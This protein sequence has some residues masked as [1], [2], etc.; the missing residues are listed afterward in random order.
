M[1]RPEV[2]VP[3]SVLGIL[4]AMITPLPAFLLDI[5]I[6]ANITLSTIV[7]LVSM[8]IRRPADFSVFPTTLL[9]MTLFRLALNV[10]SSRLILLNGSKGTSAAGEVIES[11]GNFVVGGNF[12][13]G[14]VIFLVL[15]AI[16]Y[17]VINHGAVRISEVT[18]RF[19]LD[20]LPGK[21]MSIDADL[22]GGLINEAEAKARRKSLSAEAEFYGAMDGATRFTQRDAVA[23]ILITGINIIAGFLI[24]VLQHNMRMAQALETYTVLTIGDGL[25]TVIPALMISISGG[26]IVT[27][28]SSEQEMGVDFEKQIFG[29]HQPLLLASGVLGAMALFPG[30]PKIPFLLLAGGVGYTGYRIRQKQRMAVTAPPAP[31]P[32][33]AKDSLESLMK[34]EPLSVEVG[35]GLVKLVEGAE[36]SPLLRRIAGL[37]RQLASELGYILPPVRV[38]DNLSLKVREYVVLLKGA[39]IARCELP[40]GCDLAIP[41][42]TGSVPV[43]GMPTKDPAFG[44][45]ALWISAELAERARA[46]GCTVVDPLSVMTTHLSE[47][48]RRH[49]HEIFS[50]QD[51]KR[52]LDRVSEENPRVVDDLVPKLLPLPTV[53]RVFQNLLR[54]RVSIRDANTVLES[55]GEAAGVTRNPLLLTE[56]VRQS[57]R[58]SL[59]KPHLNTAG[60]LPVFF[61]DPELERAIEQAVE[62][63]ESTSH[64][65]LPPQKVGELLEAARSAVNSGKSGWALLASAGSRSFVRQMLEANHPQITVLSHGEVPPGTKVVSM[66][67]LRGAK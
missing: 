24:G 60:E 16:Q 9:L 65:N 23:S 63:G 67:V 41:P 58:R 51:A 7:L 59:V 6:S 27:R 46:A 3:I 1:I 32:Q 12:V 20:A 28:A 26:L 36:N 45:P 57:L 8:Y 42:P 11:F 29:A 33:A 37:R 31:Q 53:Q 25:V 10:S 43:Q 55:L 35:L 50:R 49:C 4:M 34:V 66:G 54:E 39:E 52:V 62:H 61:L 19:T 2:A 17:V 21:Q 56:Y 47:L 14:V 48:V 40:Q 44:I 13:I 30:L 18:A 38:T 15:I 22:N 64:L 5:L